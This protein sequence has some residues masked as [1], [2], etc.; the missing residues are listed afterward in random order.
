MA[1]LKLMI[2]FCIFLQS[3]GVFVGLD[4]IMKSNGI[5][6]NDVIVIGESME[7]SYI[8][9]LVEWFQEMELPMAM[10]TLK[11]IAQIK[12]LQKSLIVIFDVEKGNWSSTMMAENQFLILSDLP[13]K[14]TDSTMKQIADKKIIDLG[15]K[16]HLRYDS[17]IYFGFTDYATTVNLY[18]VRES[19]YQIKKILN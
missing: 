19:K 15:M 16:Q 14:A 6:V 3:T 7:Y 4:V 8:Y 12:D 1:F 9:P 13:I 11:Q 5:G 17:Q 2:T 18:E 10:M